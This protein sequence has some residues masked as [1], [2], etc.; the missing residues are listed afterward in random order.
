VPQSGMTIT[1]TGIPP[2]ARIVLGPTPTQG[3]PIT[4]FLAWLRGVLPAGTTIIK[5]VSV[6]ALPPVVGYLATWLIV[7]VQVLGALGLSTGSL[8]ATLTAF[9]IFAVTALITLLTQHNI[10]KATY[11]PGSVN[12]RT[13]KQR[14]L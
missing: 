9:G 7:H 13:G 14:L 12:R 5:Y 2:G 4:K 1:G 6:I 11:A 3:G 10:L 8:T